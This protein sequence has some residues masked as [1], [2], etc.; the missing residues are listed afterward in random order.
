MAAAIL[1]TLGELERLPERYLILEISADLAQRQRARIARLPAALR[2]RVEWLERLPAEPLR[3]VIL[4]NEVLDALP[5][6]RFAVDADVRELGVTAD[7]DSFAWRE[8][9]E[10]LTPEWRACLP[11][12]SAGRLRQ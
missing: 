5:F 2:D 6:K 10:I 12:R 7:R 3:G 1:G 8:S 9:S 11:D 4:A